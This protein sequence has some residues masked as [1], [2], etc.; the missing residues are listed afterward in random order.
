MEQGYNC[1]AKTRQNSQKV[2]TIHIWL[3]QPRR[4]WE[5]LLGGSQPQEEATDQVAK[6]EKCQD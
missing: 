6:A 4:S 2:E 1:A 5:E 3:L